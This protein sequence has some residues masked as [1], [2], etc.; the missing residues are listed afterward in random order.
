MEAITL[1]EEELFNLC[2]DVYTNASMLVN[3]HA[4]GV[5]INERIAEFKERSDEDINPYLLEGKELERTE[6]TKKYQ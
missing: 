4:I 2:M 6:K 1:T 3:P 5:Y